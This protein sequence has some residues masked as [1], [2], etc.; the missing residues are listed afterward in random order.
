MVDLELIVA[1]KLIRHQ[2][3][4]ESRKKEGLSKKLRL[5]VVGGWST[6]YNEF[7]RMIMANNSRKWLILDLIRK[8][9]ELRILYSKNKIVAQ[10][11][12]IDSEFGKLVNGI[13][14]YLFDSRS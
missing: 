1:E 14:E 11:F 4:D 7:N 3:G 8:L 5:P 9:K 6:I 12:K 10:A 13:F 2:K